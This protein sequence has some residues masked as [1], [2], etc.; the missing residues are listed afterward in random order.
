MT[1]LRML[2]PDELNSDQQAV[3]DGLTTGERGKRSN[4]TFEDGSLVGP[5]NAM[6][7][8]PLTGNRF[9][10]LGE[11]LRFT[12]QLPQ[13]QLEIAILVVAAEWRAD[14]EWWAHARLAKAAGV[15]GDVI[16]A[17]KGG[18]QPTF[19][20][21]GEALVHAVATELLRTHRLE[22][23]TYARAVEQLGE[24]ALIDLQ[25]LMA[26]YTGI[27]MLLNS[28]EI[29]LP[30]GVPAPFERASTNP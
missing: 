13:N 8:S 27:S 15:D 5:Y 26:Y 18:D 28:F 25:L 1:R 19:S 12:N 23:G 2:T 16:E 7:Y 17:I 14:F 20:D 9:Q 21:D 6:L 11:S 10:S 30:E 22:D 4:L 29:P 24:P 3:Y